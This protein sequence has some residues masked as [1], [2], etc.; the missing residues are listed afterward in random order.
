MNEANRDQIAVFTIPCNC[1]A[2]DD[3][4]LLTFIAYL[5]SNGWKELASTLVANQTS[6]SLAEEMFEAM[7]DFIKSR[8][9]KHYGHVSAEDAL[10]LCPIP[11]GI[12]DLLPD[13]FATLATDSFKE[14][15]RELIEKLESERIRLRKSNEET[16]GA[17]F[18]IHAT[19]P[20]GMEKAKA[21]RESIRR[22]LAA[23]ELLP[24]PPEA[25]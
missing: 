22:L 3:H 18:A 19:F 8:G 4:Y 15:G 9:Y 24:T 10:L 2:D 5:N 20:L 1:S 11:L 14:G 12:I 23:W 16:T 6:A 7:P 25:F 17:L 13:E 21:V